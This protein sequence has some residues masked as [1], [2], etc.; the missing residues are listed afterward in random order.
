MLDL[1]PGGAERGSKQW[2][3]FSKVLRTC[4]ASALN[5][6]PSRVRFTRPAISDRL[7]AELNEGRHPFI[8]QDLR[9][10]G[11]NR[12]GEQ[13]CA[14]SKDGQSAPSVWDLASTL[15]TTKGSGSP[16]GH[17]TERAFADDRESE[18]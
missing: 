7:R 3:S 14:E 11:A 15:A 10:S 5:C 4:Q 2:S 16:E 12:T 1:L 8:G 17:L 18:P 13:S 6:S 9:G